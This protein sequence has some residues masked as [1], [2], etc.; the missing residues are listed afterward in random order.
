MGEGVEEHAEVVG[1][2]RA[3]VRKFTR[4]EHNPTQKGAQS[5]I[6]DIC[7][8]NVYTLYHVDTENV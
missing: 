6:L 3:R 8:S 4:A 1:T 2:K 5:G 7:N